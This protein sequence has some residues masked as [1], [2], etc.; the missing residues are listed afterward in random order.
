M[1]AA[2]PVEEGEPITICKVA[3]T[4]VF[5]HD[6]SGVVE[7]PPSAVSP[8]EVKLQMADDVESA[9]MPESGNSY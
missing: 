8:N 2:R 6:D 3:V 7:V 1:K 9:R 5:L 4:F